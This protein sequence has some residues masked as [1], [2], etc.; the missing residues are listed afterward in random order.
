MVLSTQEKSDLE[1]DGWF[2]N[3]ISGNPGIPYQ[4]NG[5]TMSYG[6]TPMK[7]YMINRKYVELDFYKP[8]GND[9]YGIAR[10]RSTANISKVKA[11]ESAPR[12][13]NMNN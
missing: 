1:N 11:M 2:D 10:E 13:P 3:T 9:Q 5:Q 6:S 8:G 4:I 12:L 7:G